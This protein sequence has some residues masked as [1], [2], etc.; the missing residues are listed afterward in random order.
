MS[1]SPCPG[2]PKAVLSVPTVST[3]SKGG[4]IRNAIRLPSSCQSRT[5]QLVTHQENCIPPNSAPVTS[6]PVSCPSTCFLETSCVGFV[7][8]PIGSH[9]ACCAPDT[10]GTLHPAASCQPCSL[11]SAGKCCDNSPCH[12][13]SD[14]GPACTSASCREAC[15]T[16]AH[17]E[18]G[19][20]QPSGSEATACAENQCLPASCEAGS[21]QPT[22]CQ[23]GSHQPIKGEGQLCKSVCYQP[24]CY[25]LK[26]CQSAPC[27]PI[28]CQTL[29]CMFSSCSQTC[30][31]P[32]SCQPVHSQLAPSFSFICQPVATCQSPC[33][34][35]NSSKSASCVMI[36]G[37]PTFN[38]SG[39]QSPSGP[40]PCCV[41]GLG[42]P[43][44]S[45]PGC[46]PPSSPNVCQAGICVPAC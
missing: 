19:S 23:G 7:C 17:C 35:K 2:N 13:S 10:G 6:E 34:V 21:C 14:Q 38:Q 15:D 25:I 31:A 27:M 37:R 16:S 3:C 28:S 1:D 18:D 44:S 41:T 5:W 36:S 32:S 12:Q 29:S 45:G 24:I 4:S 22:C 33:C 39:C 9:R 26:P 46:C 20:G 40:P 11:E 30:C 43:S 42:K 8:Q